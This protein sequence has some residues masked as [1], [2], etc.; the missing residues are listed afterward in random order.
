[1]EILR[2]DKQR[3]DFFGA[4]LEALVVELVLDDK[5]DLLAG[6][7]ESEVTSDHFFHDD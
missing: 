5:D 1:M 4:V 7:T 3:L 2:H 6:Q